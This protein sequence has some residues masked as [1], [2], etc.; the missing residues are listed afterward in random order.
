MSCNVNS[1][2]LSWTVI[3]QKV[4][5]SCK[6]ISN[7]W[8]AVSSS[9]IVDSP[10]TNAPINASEWNKSIWTSSF[11]AL[12]N[13]HSHTMTLKNPRAKYSLVDA[14]FTLEPGPELNPWTINLTGWLALKFELLIE[15]AVHVMRWPAVGLFLVK[16]RK[17]VSASALKKSSGSS[18]IGL[19]SIKCIFPSLLGIKFH[20]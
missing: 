3:N 14:I 2:Q 6:N 5:E 8:N 16:S 19:A 9:D 7:L 18:A 20:R 17:A 12:A 15:A 11:D 13:K 4:Q 1:T 10:S